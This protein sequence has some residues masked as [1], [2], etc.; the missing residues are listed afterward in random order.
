MST[1]KLDTS[2]TFQ[3]STPRSSQTGLTIP[4]DAIRIHKNGI[5][6]LSPTDFPSWTEMTV[7]L[8]SP[9]DGRKVQCTG[10]VVACDG[11]HLTGFAVSMVFV[12]LSRQSQE[13]LSLLAGSQSS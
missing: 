12:N 11:N 6:F 7:D 1:S 10:V 13:R 8:E 4:T 2:G 3:T 9:G 5:T